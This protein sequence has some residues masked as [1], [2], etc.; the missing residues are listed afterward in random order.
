MPS[1]INTS[2]S[3]LNDNDRLDITML[4]PK[5][6]QN[7]RDNGYIVGN[8]IQLS[9]EITNTIQRADFNGM[10]A[11]FAT[12]LDYFFDTD[13]GANELLLDSTFTYT[14]QTT[15]PIITLV[16]QPIRSTGKMLAVPVGILNI[17]PYS[18]PSI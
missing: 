18:P 3:I 5:L 1:T 12:A 6:T 13:Q 7:M 16:S 15:K 9:A 11:A 17:T 2:W 10:G 8:A 14:L 4:A